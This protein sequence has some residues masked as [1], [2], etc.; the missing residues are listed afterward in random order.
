MP[1]WSKF[2][3]SEI[4]LI[5]DKMNH[6]FERAMIITILLSPIVCLIMP[7]IPGR[8]GRGPM[9]DRM[10]YWDAV[11]QMSIFW[12]AALI[13][14]WIWNYFKTNSPYAANRKHLKKKKEIGKVI[15]KSKSFLS[16]F[17]NTLTTNLKGHLK[18]IKIDKDEAQLLSTGDNVEIEFEEHTKTILKVVKHQNV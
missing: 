5:K 17:E 7:Y 8:R 1:E 15:S 3:D 9:I 18:E 16:S 13:G 2:T 4:E 10:P 12:I 14:V 11:L 6:K